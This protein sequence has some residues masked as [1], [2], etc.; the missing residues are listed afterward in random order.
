MRLASILP[1][2]VLIGGCQSPKA[3]TPPATEPPPAPSP[4]DLA[5]Q[6]LHERA[7][8]T[9]QV[10]PTTPVA[11]ENEL[12][13]ARVDLGQMLFFETRLSKAQ[14][15][16]CNSCHGLDTYGVDNKPT[17][18]GHKGQRGQRN[19]PTVYNASLQLAQFWDGRAKNVEEQALGPIANPVEMAMPN[20]DHAIAVLTSIPGY[21]PLFQAAFP[22]QADPIT[23]DNVGLAIG[24]FERTL[25]TPAPFDRYLQGDL[26][27]LTPEQQTGL[28]T[29]MDTGCTT[30][31]N[32]NTVG[33]QMYQ[34]LGLV[35]AYQ[36]QDMGRYDLT[37]KDAD[38]M[39]FKVPMLRNVS[40][41][42]P[43]FHDG[44]IATLDEAI[45]TMA[46]YQLGRTLD[47]TQASQIANFL[48][49]LTGDL[50]TDRIGV[51]AMPVSGPD[52]PKPDPT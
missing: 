10:L 14:E 50:P 7:I 46:E 35:K 44:S 13:Q 48:D 25:L 40:K 21:L 31:H 8:A 12:T 29:F 42:A 3:P 45:K 43:Y 41:T 20:G 17:S 9:F 1:A 32:G 4:A 27:A 22:G 30:C 24:A 51:P 16:S 18:T 47:D 37:G 5:A 11:D 26:A 49:S 6:A 23:F 36:T 38:K 15:L 19:S 2:L 28:Q 34:K 52:T 33:G 39:F